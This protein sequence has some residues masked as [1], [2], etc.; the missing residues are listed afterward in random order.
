MFNTHKKNP[1]LKTGDALTDYEAKV[2]TVMKEIDRLVTLRATSEHGERRDS[3]EEARE[4]IE[5]HRF[6]V[7]QASRYVELILT[8]ILT[9]F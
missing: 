3:L 4:L 7:L 5:I 6:L 9:P 1:S 2:E 8:S